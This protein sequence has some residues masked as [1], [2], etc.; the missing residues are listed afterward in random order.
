MGDRT[1]T[2]DIVDGA[3]HEALAR[4]LVH[5]EAGDEQLDGRS[6]RI[7]ERPTLHFASCS[8]LGLELDPRLKQAAIEATQRYGT[9]F[10]SSRAYVSAPLY[11][12][13]ESLLDSLF[14][15]HT[16]V[17]PGTT[18]AHLAALPVLV[19]E[20][21]A[22]ILDHQVHQSVQLC[23]PQLRSQ[24]TRVEFVRHGR[25]DKLESRIRRL[26]A[27]H[28]RVWY[29]ADGVYSMY[30]DFA[31]MKAIGW[32]LE[33]YEQLHVYV[34]DAHGMSWRGRNGRGFAAEALDGHPRSVVAV[35]LNKAFGAAGGALVFPDPAL[36]QKVRNCGSTLMFT[37]PI[38]PPML[39]AAVASARI[40]LSPE[41]G[42]LQQALLERIR[43]ANRTAQELR[44][45]LASPS[46]VP[47]R[48]VPLG[49][50]KAA[51]D[52]AEHLL[53]NGVYMNPAG[54]PAVGSRH[55]GLR[56]TLTLHHELQDVRHAL[57][58]VAERLPHALAA[59]GTS[60]QEVARTFD[61]PA[62]P[63]RRSAASNALRCSHA[64][65]I[66]ELD[67]AA[68]D[69]WLGS[70]GSFDAASLR[71]LE[72]T[73]GPHQKPE[74]RWGFHYYVVRDVDDQPCLATFFTEAV[75]KDDM[76]A[77]ASVSREVERRRHT[78]PH[79]LT[80]RV[81]AMGTLL[82]EGD[83]LFLDRSRDW[84]SALWLL[85]TALESKRDELDAPALV[86]RDLADD[87][88]ELREVLDAAGFVAVALPPSMVIDLDWR[89]RDEF[90]AAR[91][92]RERRF[93]R[94]QVDPWT[95]AWEVE[96]VAGE[97]R[98]PSAAEWR[99]LHRLYANVQS[100]QLAL[101]TFPLPADLLPRMAGWP[102]WEI[103]L[104]R[105]RPE[106]G[107]EPGGFAQGFVAC[108][109]GPERY[110][111]LIVGM[112][113]RL[114]ESH[115]LYRQLLARSVERAHSLG[116]RKVSFGL[117]SELEKSRFGARPERRLLYVQS[118]DRYHH[119]VL[120]LIASDPALRC[121]G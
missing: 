45:P 10:S 49:P 113:Y 8:Y 119:D 57:E 121:A 67:G 53:A 78:D 68:W 33:R 98:R 97:G 22:V 74:N 50:K 52:M 13:L 60:R 117:G 25:V 12:E 91:S 84:K 47:V 46:E 4:G 58:L 89:D 82:T 110:T 5:L 54:F 81:L 87:D 18:L 59:A 75:W 116:R 88:L 36:R 96:V 80:S 7:G 44:V 16:V 34:D 55:A 1:R 14:E 103:L 76:L 102:G 79:F 112:D 83:H 94:E 11:E 31:P 61:L 62:P 26:V 101:N 42:R 71:L 39:G 69:R 38:Q 28:G 73:F 90:L 9:Q 17:A 27:S 86:L 70:R 6:I 105:L 63:A 65:S 51:L 32:L 92:K 77:S 85:L 107:G 21:D 104:L 115:G 108:H 120:E 56:F 2:L 43:F 100:R 20:D 109:A 23:V 48:Y 111:P 93:H 40:H 66:E 118:H 35:S 41:I 3:I 114:V 95:P 106:Y 30:G 15:A 64:S 99:H 29:L 19:A 37:G 72:Q 24:G